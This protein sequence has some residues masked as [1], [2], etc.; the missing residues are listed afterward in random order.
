LTD[1]VAAV[2]DGVLDALV[3]TFAAWTLVYQLCAALELAAGWA[4]VGWV[5][6]A[7]AALAA[8]RASAGPRPAVEVEERPPAANL[9]APLAG[10]AVLGGAAA[11]LFAYVDVLWGVVWL[12]WVAAAAGALTVASRRRE[13]PARHEVGRVELAVVAVWAVGFAV[14]SLFL[15]GPAGDDAYYVHLSTWIGEHG[16]FP[17]RDVVHSDQV[18]PALYYPPVNSFE[19]LAGTIAHLST[20]RAP[21]VVYFGIPPLFSALTVLALWRLLRAWAVPLVAIALSVACAFLLFDAVGSRMYGAFSI[22]RMWHG[23]ALFVTVLVPVLFALVHRFAARPDRRAGALLVAGGIAGV[24]LT[25]TAMFVVPVIAAGAF[26]PLAWRRPRTALAGLVAL[27]GYPT[28]AAL[29][30]LALGGRTPDVY[31]D[32][33]MVSEYLLRFVLGAGGL[34]L[35]AL[36]AIL[37]G[38][39]L[40]R[41]GGPAVAGVALIVG[42]LYGPHVPELIFQAT[43][44]GRVLWR[45]TWAL[46]VAALAGSLATTLLPASV[47][48]LVRAAPA[49]VL[50]LALVVAGQ[51]IWTYAGGSQLVSRPSWKLAPSEIAQAEAIL[52]RSAPGDV[53]L[54]PP[55]LSVALLVLSADV[56]PVVS[57]PFY[58][59][60]L[61]DDRG[62]R[63]PAR[64]QLGAFVNTAI[65][66]EA[67]RPAERTVRRALTVLG[68]DLACLP[69]AAEVEQGVLARAGYEAVVRPHGLECRTAM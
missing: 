4:V 31:R 40:L 39:A 46:P 42:L 45:L 48:R 32:E 55:R 47:P 25:T 14:L 50:V 49:F 62:A 36:L 27:A 60:S 38:P 61:A 17:L 16:R 28:I 63:A 51:P 21:D 10:V 54:V 44:L 68:V 12:L 24:G 34:A 53:V 58:V 19:A 59:Q 9:R 52:R 67:R 56:R 64:L 65:G 15:L 69:T 22:G 1:R 43:G 5:L 26:A 41:R 37:V 20:I 66:R 6:V 3:V 23:K 11:I 8:M 13:A 7:A 33:Q 57:R 35:I 2:C 29:A 30:T 18:L